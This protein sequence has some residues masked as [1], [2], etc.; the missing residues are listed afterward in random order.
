MSWVLPLA[1]TALA[2][3]V[4]AVAALACGWRDRREAAPERKPR[5]TPVP[6]VG[7][8]A[9]ALGLGAG[10]L[11]SPLAL[12][13]PALAAALA[14]G[15]L[16]DVLPRGLPA[17]GKL[18]GQGIAAALLALGAPP[19]GVDAAL[20]FAVAILAMNALNTWD[21]VDGTA[22]GLGLLG[23]WGMGSAALA[24]AV[25]GFLPWNL[26]LRR[27]GEEGRER[28]PVAYLGDGGSHFLGILIAWRFE[29]WPLL[30]L[31]LLDLARLSW[32]RARRG[33][34]PWSG[35]RLHLAHR[36]EGSGWRPIPLAA[37][38]TALA[39]PPLVAGMLL[40]GPAAHLFGMA[41]SLAGFAIVV[42]GTS[43][44]CPGPE[45]RG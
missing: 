39:A 38:L 33:R 31:P 25:A 4:L 10:A 15:V 36:L 11:A 43:D 29:C 22:A 14:V 41:V 32:V 17:G 6:P 13:W 18:L 5:R 34:P 9:I 8:I 40:Q 16:D 2:T 37:F 7:G 30:L 35:D 45:G 21:N 20:V 23:A 42:R 19:G 1:V 27:R 44:P 26:L 12:P 24:G 28:V 3:P